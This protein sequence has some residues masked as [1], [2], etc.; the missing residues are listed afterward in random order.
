L[1]FISIVSPLIATA[2]FAWGTNGTLSTTLPGLP[3]F[4]C[5]ALVCLAWLQAVRVL[6]RV[7]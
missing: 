3:F 4:V 1:S 5:A 7:Q 2:L 6:G